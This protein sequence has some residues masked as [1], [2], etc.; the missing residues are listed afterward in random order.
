MPVPLQC[1]LPLVM[2][3]M[4]GDVS[5]KTIANDSEGEDAKEQGLILCLANLEL[6]SSVLSP[7][8]NI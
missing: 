1:I 4:I 2:R 5:E 6:F 7:K 8:V 3:N